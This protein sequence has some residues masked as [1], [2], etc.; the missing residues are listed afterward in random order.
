ERDVFAKD[1]QLLLVVNRGA[2]A[3]RIEQEGGVENIEVVLGLRIGP[4]SGVVG[5][6]NQ[7][8]VVSTDEVGDGGVADLVEFRHGG[9]R[10]DEQFGLV[11]ER[12]FGKLQQLPETIR[13]RVRVPNQS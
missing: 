9:F 11:R 3:L 5:I 1:D 6:A 10:P 8:E 12:A 4:P 7:P 2:T 13:V